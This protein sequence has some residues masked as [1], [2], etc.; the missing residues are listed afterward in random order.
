MLNRCDLS[1]PSQLQSLWLVATQR[2]DQGND[3]TCLLQSANIPCA[4]TVMLAKGDD[5]VVVD[6][7]VA[8][9]AGAALWVH[10]SAN[11]PGLMD[12]A[13]QFRI[14]LTIS[15][16]W[17]RAQYGRNS[18]AWMHH[19]NATWMKWFSVHAHAR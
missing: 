11:R 8:A 5:S 9:C 6:A 4:T 19:M 12:I 1:T 17:N 7:A 3:S 16:T 10:A 18:A 14:G 13:M 15:A 2:G